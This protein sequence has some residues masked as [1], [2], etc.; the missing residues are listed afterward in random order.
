M[1][2]YLYQLDKR[3]IKMETGREETGGSGTGILKGSEEKEG[4]SV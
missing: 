4:K 1:L 2:F 3:G